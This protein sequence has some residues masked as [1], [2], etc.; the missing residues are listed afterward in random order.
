MIVWV[1]GRSGATI[2]CRDRGLQYG[3]GLF[4]TMRV[5]RRGVR[6]LDFHLQRL[7]AGC[8]RLRIDLPDAGRLR[9]EITRAAAL[10][11]DGVL[12]LIVTRG[13]GARG[14]RPPA[15]ARTTRILTLGALPAH[16]GANASAAAQVRLCTTR[17]GANERLAGLK[18]LN[19]LESVLAR[20]EWRDERIFEGLMLDTDGYIVCGTMS[21][22]F[23][24]RGAN[25]LTPSI[26]R[27]GVEGVMRRWVLEQ[28]RGIG[29]RPSVRRVRIEDLNAAHE[30]FLSNAIMGLK[31]VAMFARGKERVRPASRQ[32]ALM[33]RARLDAL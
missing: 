19:R 2:D 6:L 16:A 18:T 14:Y 15:R 5:R 11:D 1:N 25:L 31:S 22:V 21:N 8:A 20:M 4:E 29:L 23:L 27:C 17:L 30:M 32:T 24:R 12:K 7:V 9:R 13:V 3:D 28:A 26:D 10:R 33:L